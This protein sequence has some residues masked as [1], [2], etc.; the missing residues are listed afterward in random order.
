MSQ[1]RN[2]YLSIDNSF[3]VITIYLLNFRVF[4]LILS[5]TTAPVGTLG[6]RHLFI[7]IGDQVPKANFGTPDGPD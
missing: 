5:Y 6:T 1:L 3:E 4:A 2:P 7:I